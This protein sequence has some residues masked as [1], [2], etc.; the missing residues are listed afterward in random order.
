MKGFLVIMKA[1]F[2]MKNV[3]KQRKHVGSLT[4]S[5]LT[6][7]QTHR[8]ITTLANKKICVHAEKVESDIGLFTSFWCDNIVFWMTQHGRL[9]MTKKEK[10]KKRKFKNK[11]MNYEISEALSR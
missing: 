11:V 5:Y 4:V 10:K 7:F 3:L 9:V 6:W 1:F 2:Q 8:T